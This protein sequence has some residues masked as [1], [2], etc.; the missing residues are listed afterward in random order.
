MT[1]MPARLSLAEKISG[2]NHIVFGTLI[3]AYKENLK[4]RKLSKQTLL[5]VN[6]RLSF[7][8]EKIGDVPIKIMDVKFI[9]DFISEKANEGKY[10]IANQYRSLIIEIFHCGIAQGACESNPASLTKS[11]RYDIEKSRLTFDEYIK[12]REAANKLKPWVGL[13]FDLAVVT[14]QREGDLAKMLWTDIVDQKLQ[15]VQ[16]KTKTMIRIP[17]TLT[18]EK[19]SL[20]LGD[21]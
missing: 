13:C 15:V 6:H 16:S 19:L 4:S 21:I 20:N 8:T 14:G 9:H 5:T 3:D 11:F 2:K 1:M 12:I 17:L 18:V 10:A 7:I